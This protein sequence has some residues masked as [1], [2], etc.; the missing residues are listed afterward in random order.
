[1][2]I[3]RITRVGSGIEIRARARADTATCP[4]CEQVSLRVHSRYDRWLDDAAIGGQPVRIRLSVRRFVC[5][6]T[7]CARKTFVEQVEGL[8]VRY[9]RRS[10]LLT[11]VLQSIGLALAGRAGARLTDELA[12]PVSRMTL[13]RLIRG[14]PDPQVGDV[15]AVGIDDFA[16]RRG[17]KY[18]TVVIDI[19]SHRSLDV[20]PDRTSDTVADWL[21]QHPGIQVVCRDRAGAYAEAA[22]A[23]APNAIQVA[24]RWHLWHNLAQAVE[25]TVLAQRS[26]LRP[27]PAEPSDADTSVDPARDATPAR[28]GGRGGDA[29]SAPARLAARTRDRHAAVR[30]LRE[31]G[32][33]IAAISRELGLDRRTVRR[34][35]RTSNAEELLGNTGPRS[36]LL[37]AYKPYLQ[38]RFTAGHTNAVAL[39][40]EITAMGYAGSEKTVRLYLHPFRASLTRPAPAPAPAAPS[41]RQVTSWLTRHPDHLNEEQRLE[42]KNILGRSDTLT[43]T[44]HQVRQF[45]EMLTG[46]HGDRL[47]AWM[48]NVEATGPPA[49]RSFARG[50]ATDLDAVTAGLTLDFSSGAVEGTVNRIK[51]IKRQMYGRAKFDLL[52]KRILNPA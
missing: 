18:G 9:G 25:K 29:S 10:P 14:L 30:E 11:A 20:L 23:G 47:Q 36:S 45:A 49:L 21:R 13:L 48:N 4:G 35:V 24:D 37:D 28:P 39:S 44:Q 43:V 31:R 40:A 16:L 15:T 26:A 50:L 22:R 19:N 41:V 8:T 3:E 1:M 32:T 34:F 33:S 17:H 5:A 7:R 12:A 6:T 2:R 27:D 42:L 52:R 46:R 38:E 51:T